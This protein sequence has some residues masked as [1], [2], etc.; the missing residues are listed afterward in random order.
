M[1]Y[2]NP[3]A[4]RGDYADPFVLKYN[5]RYFLYCTNPDIRCWSSDDLIHWNLEGAAIGEDIFPN[6]VPFAP[7]VV[8]WNGYFYMYTSPSGF[9]H[10]ILRSESPKGPFRKISENIG[11]AID[12]TVFIDDDGTWY[13]YW[14]GEEG[15]WGCE[16][17][18]PTEFGEPVLT[19]AF[20]N[21][22]TE[23]PLVYKKDGI[24]YM[25]YTG[26]HYL[27]KGYR[28]N[29]CWSRHPLLG[30]Q[31]DRYNPVAVRTAGRLN[32][33]GHSSTVEGPDLISDYIIYHNTNEDASRDLNIDR[34][35]WYR[36]VTQ[37]SGPTQAK[38]YVPALPDYALGGR[39]KAVLE[40]VCHRGTAVREG[41]ILASGSE[42]M[43]VLSKQIF[44]GSF[45]I[46]CNMKIKSPGTNEGAGIVLA[47]GEDDYYCIAFK[48]NL[49]IVQVL[50]RCGETEQVVVQSC[51][52][53]DYNFN[54][55]HCIKLCQNPDGSLEVYIDRRLQLMSNIEKCVAYRIGCTAD[56][57]G[58]EIG[59]TA[60]TEATKQ[61]KTEAAVFPAE[62]AFYPV[63]GKISGNRNA[64]GS[65]VLK[66]DE[67]AQYHIWAGA[68]DI[69]HCCISTNHQKN[70]LAEVWIDNKMTGTCEG[71][72]GLTL[73]ET[74][75]DYGMHTLRFRN[76][77]G[78]L[79]IKRIK[80]YPFVENVDYKNHLTGAELNGYEKRLTDSTLL[81]DY[82]V[83]AVLSVKCGTNG[84]AGIL[85][86][87]TE[88]SEGG[89]GDD[90]VMGTDFFIG[91]SVSLTGT[92]LVVLRH[93]YDEKV[94]GRCRFYV[95]ADKEYQLLAEISGATI[96]V[97][98]EGKKQPEIILTDDEPIENGCA[99]IWVKN[100]R[101]K[102]I[103]FG[104]QQ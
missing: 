71:S 94:L 74:R 36:E 24:Y 45:T 12:G 104:L 55:L 69:Y 29:A 65:I 72:T 44:E 26:N 43:F 75:L 73:I 91:Y 82:A 83:S 68:G 50:H 66:Q 93:R 57:D 84:N 17:K 34:Q 49:K 33:L 70:G 86:R 46:E 37:I 59:Y 47:I 9:G 76:T 23:G 31:D 18:S 27:S 48:S 30:Y 39:G 85:L 100:S 2:Q 51:L 13:F 63:F 10:Y 4:K 78:I 5:G 40:L 79:Q 58:L 88:P 97:Y 15:I 102:V 81:S 28:I 98:M 25:T 1:M 14:A 42:G 103:D 41:D 35:L 64:D 95:E 87:V 11:H 38:Q 22:W 21:G 7:E 20:L 67:D 56:T 3:I 90:T 62:C 16:M 80:L 8:Y 6:M 52:P 54:V 89:E 77:S 99:G 19:G 61:E 92:E 96:T 101:M 53:E 60:V 32:G